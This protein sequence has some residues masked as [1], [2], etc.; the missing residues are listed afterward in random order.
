MNSGEIIK[1]IAAETNLKKQDV[2]AIIEQYLD[3]VQTEIA[4]NGK[5]SNPKFGTF[6]V[7]ARAARKGR[8]PKTGE[9][10]DIPERKAVSF[11]A[12]PTLTN[13]CNPED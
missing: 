4:F 10:I 12:A 9:P 6:S 2:K 13:L 3:I 1:K 11:R 5:F 7:V 8:N